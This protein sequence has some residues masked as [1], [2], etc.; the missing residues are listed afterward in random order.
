MGGEIGFIGAC[1]PEIDSNMGLNIRL[2]ERFLRYRVRTPPEQI[3]RKIDRALEIFMKEDETDDEVETLSLGFLKW[4]MR[5]DTKLPQLSQLT[6][7]GRLAQLGAIL[8]T[9][10]SRTSYGNNVLV[11]PVYEEATRFAKC[12]AKVALSLAYIR[13]KDTNDDEEFKVLK[14]LVRDALDSRVELVAK[15]IFFKPDCNVE[16]LERIT[17]LP[18]WTLKQLLSDLIVSRIIVRTGASGFSSLYDFRPWIRGQ[19]D[20]FQLWTKD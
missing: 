20:E 14:S 9:G 1:T 19:L 13:G 18:T 17:Y 6:Q 4:L 10:V 3:Y 12:L 16:Y 5:E 11:V 15:A 2:G 8:R 7:I